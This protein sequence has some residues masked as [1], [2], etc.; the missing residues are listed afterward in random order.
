MTHDLTPVGGALG[1]A[2]KSTLNDSTLPW[3]WRPLLQLLARG[4]PVTV[5]DLAQATGRDADEVRRTVAALPD[6]EYDE[7]GRILGYGL[8]QR[9]TSHRFCIG[10]RQLFAWCALDTLMFPTVLDRTAH[11]E[12]PCHATGDP[13]RAHVAP[14]ALL[15][16]EPA[17][18]V[19]SIVTPEQCTSI[20]ADFCDQVH[21]FTSAQAAQ[22]W[23][24]EHP[25]AT[26][27]PVA[28]ALTLG[29]Q[30]AQ[31]HLSDDDTAGCC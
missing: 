26:V 29:H 5:D 2:L 24:D 13:I 21:F 23:L 10:G 22:P 30:L 11:V 1:D 20:R 31:G 15:S 12:S 9:P 14:G 4:E 8:T 16:V 19:V 7:Q 18:A 3:L 27:L 25:D 28:E 17:S 6:T